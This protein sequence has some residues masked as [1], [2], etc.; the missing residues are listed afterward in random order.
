MFETSKNNVLLQLV[1]NDE[2]REIEIQNILKSSTK[3]KNLPP[4]ISLPTKSE[5]TLE[6]GEI[7]DYVIEY[8]P[9]VHLYSEERYLPYDIK[10]YIKEFRVEFPNGTVVPGTEE[11]MN[12]K[13]FGDLA[14]L[15]DTDELY[16]MS[17]SD[18][19]LDP[20]WITGIKNKPSLIDG[21]IKDAPA[22]LIV[23]DKGNGWVDSYWFYFYSFNLGPFVMGSGPYGNHVGDWEHSLV[24][25]YNGQPV[26][27]WM[28]AHGGGGGFYYHNL[29]KYQ[30]NP[31]HPIIFSARGTHAN[32]P[33]VGQY[34][35]DLPYGILSDF[36]DRGPLW[37]PTKN[38][39]SYTYDGQYVYPGNTNRNP[40]HI[41]RELS[42][43]NWLSYSGQWGDKQLPLKD[44]RQTYSLVAGYKQIDGPKGPLAKN[45]LRVLPCERTK[46][47]NFWGGCNVRQNIKWGIGVESEGYN[48][49]NMFMS[50]RPAFLR[51]AFQR[52][53]WGGGFCFFM[54]IIYG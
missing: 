27:V 24:R 38:Y 10:S 14:K 23:V 6:K 32:Y 3:F 16:L 25:F 15:Y 42:Y 34:P 50:I 53:T 31:K 36:T 54:D 43:H 52:F 12:I 26:I 44:P 46:W 7:P 5:R 33:S 22:T 13:K 39:L 37:N 20:N 18:F 11:D 2:D 48:C 47:W 29:E 17:N 51:R 1:Q 28:S 35:H 49:G 4:I 8:A 45:L 41:G 30:L 19:S 40:K 9:L 21:E